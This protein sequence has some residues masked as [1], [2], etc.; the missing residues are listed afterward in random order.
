M[1]SEEPL[2]KL[3]EAELEDINSVCDMSVPDLKTDTALPVHQR[4]N[5]PLA[6]KTDFIES[7]H[8]T[9]TFQ[10]DSNQNVELCHDDIYKD[11]DSVSELSVLEMKADAGLPVQQSED[12]LQLLS[13][14]ETENGFPSS[15][16]NP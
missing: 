1:V 2:P 8:L 13:V 7:L 5:G 3:P 9:S 16:S 14:S 10:I 11:I 15:I 6:E 12:R 4:E